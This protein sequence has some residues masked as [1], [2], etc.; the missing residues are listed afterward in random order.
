[1]L[2]I[3]FVVP[4]FPFPIK[5]GLEK[6]SLILSKELTRQGL[7]V[8]VL[9]SNF[10]SKQKELEFYQG[11][12]IVRPNWLKYNSIQGGKINASSI[13][14]SFFNL[15]PTL[16]ALGDFDVVHFHSNSF[17][18]GLIHLYFY[19]KNIPVVSKIPNSGDRG[20][21]GMKKSVLGMLRLKI[22]ALSTRI[23][24]L[25]KESQSELLKVGIPSN[26]INLIPNGIEINPVSF[27]KNNVL[28]GQ[29]NVCFVG[30][31]KP[32]KG[33]KNLIN[34]WKEVIKLIPDFSVHLDIYGD[35]P[36]KDELLELVQRNKLNE[37]ITFHGHVTP[38]GPSLSRAQLFVLPSYFE[39]NSNALLEAMS[40]SL[41]IAAS[42]IPG[43]IMQVG[44]FGERF[45]FNPDN[46]DEFV[47]ILIELV[48]NSSLRLEYGK[49]LFDRVNSV[50]NIEKVAKEYI[51]LYQ[52]ILE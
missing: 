13:F 20:V 4:K 40:F 27:E 10:D 42:K 34:A 2:K 33:I 44:E 30:R 48:K 24:C 6:Q 32:Q 46:I 29:V 1:M 12:K 25:T 39:G 18:T 15:L 11:V 52:S 47:N 51:K 7:N 22:L 16:K 9:S 45:L 19:K 26:K 21:L 43:N 14:F 3:L 50:F 5:G 35:G 8:T 37:Y 49:Y 41:P 28:N 36:L 38:I 17:L 31:L 23:V